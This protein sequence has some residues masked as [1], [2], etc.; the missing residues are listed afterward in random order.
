M[1]KDG[2]V[3]RTTLGA[4]AAKVLLTVS[5]RTNPLFATPA[6]LLEPGCPRFMGFPAG[7]L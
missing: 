2:A 4:R 7:E 1:L 6:N 5:L 3:G